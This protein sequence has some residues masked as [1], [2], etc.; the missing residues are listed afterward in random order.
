MDPQNTRRTFE[1]ACDELE[2][3]TI[4]RADLDVRILQLKKTVVALAP[5]IG[6]QPA[7]V[8]GFMQSIEDA[9][10]TENCREVL[11]G[12]K[13][14][15]TP[16]EVRNQLESIGYKFK[17]SNPLAPIHAVLKRLVENHE[18]SKTT[19]EEGDVAYQ[20]ILRFPRLRRRLRRHHRKNRPAFGDK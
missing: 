2:V 8:E 10:I 13:K 6:H 4:E 5:L 11:R 14:A 19:T 15:L 17:T 9:G 12:A 20:W 16:I 18:V 3:L 1:D 7:F